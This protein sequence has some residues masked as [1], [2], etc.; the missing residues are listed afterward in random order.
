MTRCWASECAPSRPLR[1]ASWRGG[2]KAFFAALAAAVNA[3][4]GAAKLPF[5]GCHLPQV[6]NAK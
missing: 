5:Q 2:V 4:L 1:A 3:L 6:Q